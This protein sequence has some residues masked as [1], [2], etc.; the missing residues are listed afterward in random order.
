M[1]HVISAIYLFT[2]VGW[3]AFSIALCRELKRGRDE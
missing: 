3:V 1:R 2:V